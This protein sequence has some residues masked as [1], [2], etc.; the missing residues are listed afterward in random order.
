MRYIDIGIGYWVLGIG[1]G[2]GQYHWVLDIRCL[3]WYRS[4]PRRKLMMVIY[5]GI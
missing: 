1:I 4:T 3:S 2:T 5:S